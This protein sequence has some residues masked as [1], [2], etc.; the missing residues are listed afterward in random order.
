MRFKI[1]KQKRSSVEENPDSLNKIDK[2]LAKLMKRKRKKDTNHQ[3]QE[4]NGCYFHRS[5]SPSKK[6]RFY[7]WLHAHNLD[8][9]NR[10]LQNYKQTTKTQPILNNMNAYIY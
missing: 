5:C 7:H 10:L 3:Y 2:V 1:G 4:R 6:I 8:E 9:M